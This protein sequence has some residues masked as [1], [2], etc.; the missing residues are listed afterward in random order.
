[1]EDDVAAGVFK[2]LFEKRIQFLKSGAWVSW[3]VV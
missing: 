2:F 3:R 1:M